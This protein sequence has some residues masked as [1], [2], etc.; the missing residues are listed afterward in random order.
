MFIGSL[1]LPVGLTTANSTLQILAP[2][3][4]RARLLSALLMVSFGAQPLASLL[5]GYS[6]QVLGALEA[7]RANGLLMAS[8]AAALLALRPTLRRWEPRTIATRRSQRG[9]APTAIIPPARPRP[10][11]GEW[12]RFSRLPA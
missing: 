3:D 9:R 10:G 6:A 5:V 1:A 7:V 4:M 2:P 11:Q 8:G 12:G